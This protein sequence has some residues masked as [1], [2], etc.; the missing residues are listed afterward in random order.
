LKKHFKPKTTPTGTQGQKCSTSQKAHA[1]VI[2]VLGKGQSGTPS[3][4]NKMEQ[5]DNCASLLRKDLDNYYT[6]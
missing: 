2:N 1:L 6:Q 4:W 3:G 5:N